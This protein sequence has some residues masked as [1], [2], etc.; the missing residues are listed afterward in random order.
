[1]SRA[2]KKSNVSAERIKAFLRSRFNPVRNLEP[3]LLSTYLDQFKQGYFSQIAQ[4]WDTIEERDDTLSS[5]VNKRKK[6]VSR[7]GW[8]IL[9]VDDADATE[10]EAH[11]EALT[12]FYNNITVTNAIDENEQGEVGLLVRQMM[13]AVGKRYAVHE[14]VWQPSAEGITAHFRFVPLWFFENTT[15]RLRFLASQGATYG[16]DLEDGA[17]M[18]TVGDGLMAASS[19]AWMFKSLSLKD[20][21]I[22]S[23]K[24]GIPGVH[25]KTDS[26]KDSA[27]WENLVD[28][29]QNFANDWAVVTNN[30]AEI[31]L[32]DAS[33]KGT[34]PFPPL[35]ERMSRAIA[36]IWRGADLSTISAGDGDGSGASLQGEE[37]DIIEQDDAALISETLSR[38]IDRRVIEYTFGRGVRPAAYFRL[39]T[40]TRQNVELDMRTDEFLLN[41]GAPL[42][43]QATLE[44]YGRQMP[45]DTAT[46]LKPVASPLQQI[47]RTDRSSGLFNSTRGGA[48]G[49]AARPTSGGNFLNRLANSDGRY[50]AD[51]LALAAHDEVAQALAQDLA[52]IRERLEYILAIEDHDYRINA[53]KNLQA[54]LPRYLEEIN[55]DPKAAQALEAALSAALLNGVAEAGQRS[56][57]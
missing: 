30:G 29:V 34:L 43:V 46:L 45:E 33:A 10:V 56:A 11:T 4:I 16:V 54:E 21:L 41:A 14:V 3:S 27:E 31:A 23:E 13:D 15:G 39:K 40:S 42:D 5:V 20:W 55:V 25:G 36:A 35:V 28:A 26:Q 44:R 6:S 49:K 17:W 32:I 2:K 38:N 51:R 47:T 37:A 53:L 19:I 12:R 50:V 57:S 8:D 7:N 48:A 18:V 1:M 9:P 22:Y 52:P 24:C